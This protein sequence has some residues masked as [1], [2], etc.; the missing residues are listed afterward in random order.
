MLV[1]VLVRRAAAAGGF[2]TVLTKG[3]GISGAILIQAVE[4]GQEIALFER[5]SDFAGGYVLMACGPAA[6]EGPD[7]MAAY[8]D[9]RRRADPDLW[10]VELDIADAERFAAETIC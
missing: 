2:V 7:A 10:I 6:D 5:M 8:I 1:G 3:D 9:R 4:K